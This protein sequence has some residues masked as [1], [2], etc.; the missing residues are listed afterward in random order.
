[1]RKLALLSFLVA[2]LACRAKETL[3]EPGAILVEVRS[4]GVDVA[5]DELRAWVYDDTGALWNGVRIPAEGPLH[6]QSS[7]DLGTV[8]VQPGPIQG[9]LRI[10]LRALSAGAR[11]SDGTLS[12]AAPTAGKRTFTLI[13]TAA[14]PEDLDGDDVPDAIDDCPGVGNPTQ[15]GCPPATAPDAGSPDDTRSPYGPETQGTDGSDVPQDAIAPDEDAT[16]D[17]VSRDSVYAD[18]EPSPPDLR[19]GQGSTDAIRTADATSEPIGR[20]ASADSSRDSPKPVDAWVPDSA[21]LDAAAPDSAGEVGADLDAN[22][23]PACPD[24]GVCDR[25]QGEL[26]A[27]NG[28]CASGFCADGVCCTNACV[29]P[30]RSCNQPN[31]TGVCQGYTAGTDPEAECGGV[32]ACNGVGACGPSVT[33]N[34]PNGQLCS[35]GTQCRS[36]YCTDGVC[37]DVPCTDPC[38]TCG[39]GACQPVK[40]TDDVPECTGNNTCNPR[41]MCIAR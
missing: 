38:Q 31:A 39:T 9:S 17:V 15:G 35:S 29:G 37:C 1:M 5:P 23:A 14:L 22:V 24:G 36:G 41:G 13:L 33:P 26:C 18:H 40:K 30:C 25:A 6:V 11:L 19:D 2:T 20:D 32:N 8:L 34:L 3:P 28:E 7:Q 12:I 4:E 21:G 10:H 27:N 16:V